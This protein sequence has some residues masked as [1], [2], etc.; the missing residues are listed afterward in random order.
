MSAHLPVVTGDRLI[1]ALKRHG[2]TVLRQ[3]GSHI[4]L[5]RGDRTISVS[6]H[7]KQDVPVGTLASILDDAGLT[8]DDL[9][10]LL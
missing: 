1:R 2:W 9:R 10:R 5:R 6:A 7:A 4:R 3:R 8:P